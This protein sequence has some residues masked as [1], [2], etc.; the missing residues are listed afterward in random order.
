[1]TGEALDSDDEFAIEDDPTAATVT[2]DAADEVSS[3]EDF[4]G[5][6]RSRSYRGN[7][8]L[9]S[10]VETALNPHLNLR[11]LV[12]DEADRLMDMGFEP[13]VT[14]IMNL[15]S[16]RLDKRKAALARALNRGDVRSRLSGQKRKYI[17]LDQRRTL[18]CS[19]TI[20]EN[21]E[22]LAGVALKD[23]LL[24][25]GDSE[26]KAAIEV[27]NKPTDGSSWSHYAPPSQLSQLYAVVEPK[28][29][30]VTLVALLRQLLL[31]PTLKTASAPK[32]L[33][34]LSCTDSVDL[35]WHAMANLQM[36]RNENA[37]KKTKSKT[38]GSDAVRAQS[39]IL[40]EASVYR[41][42]GSL[43]LKTRLASLKDFANITK[44]AAVLFCTSVAARGLD[45]PD[46]NCVIQY[47]LPTEVSKL[48]RPSIAKLTHA[49][50]GGVTEYVHRVGRTARAGASGQSWAFLLPPEA[51][52]VDWA[53]KE[54]AQASE[55]VNEKR[56]QLRTIQTIL[57]AGYGGKDS[58]DYENRA[59]DVQMAYERWVADDASVSQLYSSSRLTM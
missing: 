37:V 28:L 54:M 3:D 47:D 6:G 48:S 10:G 34:F 15:L 25:K 52:W 14:S 22:K 11:W 24:I 16:A 31:S 29:R 32:I 1:M 55:G 9:A 57:K 27:G 42:H 50:Q 23:P 49:A 44:G 56:L 2:K 8:P 59:T 33:V 12:L 35:H 53:E 39:E 36:G 4:E 26:A 45:V 41:L 21:V 46:V 17:E 43:D 13:Q 51:A 20:Q 7:A 30:F 5:K 18:L 19:A 40:P 58:R 38:A